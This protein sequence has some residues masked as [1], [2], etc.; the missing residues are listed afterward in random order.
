M[1]TKKNQYRPL[2]VIID[3]DD[4]KE[5]QP[6]WSDKMCAEFLIYYAEEFSEAC[7]EYMQDCTVQYEAEVTA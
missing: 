7:L 2:Q 3:V 6:D 1:S 5:V 4:V